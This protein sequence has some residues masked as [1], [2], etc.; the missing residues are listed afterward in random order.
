MSRASLPQTPAE[1]AYTQG[2]NQKNSRA[3][4]PLD[5]ETKQ[6][7]QSAQ[8]IDPSASQDGANKNRNGRRR[9]GKRPNPTSSDDNVIDRDGFRANVGMV[10]LNDAGQV[11]WGRRV[12]V[13]GWQFPQGGIRPDET[14]EDAMFRELEEEVGLGP[15]QV[16]VVG[17]TRRW[18]R[19]R[20]PERFIRRHQTPLCIGQ[21]QIW[22]ALRLV[23]D[24]TEVRLNLTDSPEFQEWRWVEYWQP[25][26]EVIRFKRGVY[27]RALRELAN[28]AAGHPAIQLKPTPPSEWGPGTGQPERASNRPPH[29]GRRSGRGDR[30][31]D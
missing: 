11:F 31:R 1:V 22:F 27:R 15:E 16:E 26:D 3:Q 29:S 19:Y 9:S 30:S 21:K 5:V 17:C 24:E 10:L 6:R 2:H 14:P 28:L 18:L 7:T 20:L 25:A 12:G 4:R 8:A 13:S 23:V